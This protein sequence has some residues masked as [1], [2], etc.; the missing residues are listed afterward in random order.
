MIHICVVNKLWLISS[1][2]S[3]GAKTKTI[4]TRAC[5]VLL[6]FSSYVKLVVYDRLF[7]WLQPSL[8]LLL[9]CYSS[10]YDKKIKNY[11]LSP[12]NS[13][14]KMSEM[15]FLFKEKWRALYRCYSDTNGFSHTYLPLFQDKLSKGHWAWESTM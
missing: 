7:T 9:Y 6:H 8:A 5:C 10:Q 1:F 13:C 11:N 14:L 4:T 15:E 12:E 2:L 3:R